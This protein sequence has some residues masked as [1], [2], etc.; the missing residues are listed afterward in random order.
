MAKIRSS[1]DL[2]IEKIFFNHYAKGKKNFIFER[3]E[4]ERTAD[5]LKVEKPKNPGDVVYSY[6]YRKALPDSIRSK[7]TKGHEWIILG[8]KKGEYQFA[9]AKQFNATPNPDLAETKI[10]DATPEIINRYALTD[11]QALLAKIRYNRLIDIFTGLTCYSLQNHLRTKILENVQIE[12]DEVYVGMDKK[13]VHYVLPI[14]AKARQ[15]QLGGV[16][17]RQDSDVCAERFPDAVCRL[18]GAKFA[19]NDVISLF[20]FEIDLPDIKTVAEKHYR[21]VSNEE[22]TNDKLGQYQRR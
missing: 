14:Q 10:P 19:D 4:I 9:L 2:I 3:T 18:I 5:S 15:E 11:E 12:T 17:I 16:Q 13:G 7:A 6:R 8:T 22:L 20:E 1:Y 21:L